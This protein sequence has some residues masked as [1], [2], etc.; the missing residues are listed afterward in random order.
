MELTAENYYGMEANKAY[1]SV[2]QFKDFNGTY[3][4]M[5]CEFEAME[6]LEERWK[7]D[8]VVGR[9]LCGLVH[10]GNTG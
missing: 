1:M 6:K 8:S 10:R 2:S 3:G 5:A 9:K 7:P 4:K